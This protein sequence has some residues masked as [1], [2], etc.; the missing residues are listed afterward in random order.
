MMAIPDHL[1]LKTLNYRISK[2]E[3]EPVFTVSVLPNVIQDATKVGLKWE[4]ISRS[5]ELW[6]IQLDFDEPLNIS[7]EAPDLIEINFADPEL[8]I[9]DNGIKI[10]QDR[11]KISRELT[12]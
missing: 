12:R 5:P 1:D 7:F 11:R 2:F 9:S 3:W 4:F 10:P 8:F 6:E